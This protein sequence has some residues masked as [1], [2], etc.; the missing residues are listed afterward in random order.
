MFAS[1]CVRKIAEPHE[2]CSAHF[3]S[4]FSHSV[5]AILVSHMLCRLRGF[6]Q[7]LDT[8]PSLLCFALLF[9]GEHWHCLHIEFFGQFFPPCPLSRK[10]LSILGL[11]LL[12][13]SCSVTLVLRERECCDERCEF[14]LA[15]LLFSLPLLHLGSI[16]GGGSNGPGRPLTPTGPGGQRIG[17]A[18]QPGLELPDGPPR[19]A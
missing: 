14:S 15:V 11:L 9:C 8:L 3:P 4:P 10:A 19:R 16:R 18:A 12:S 1:T 17:E 7:K 5:P 6:G 2:R 13:P